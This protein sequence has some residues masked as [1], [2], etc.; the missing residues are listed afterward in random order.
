MMQTEISIIIPTLNEEKYLDTTLKALINQNTN[1]P[2]E[3]IVS[4]GGSDDG[5]IG[6]AKLYTDKVIHCKEVGIGYGR[7]F[8]A[9]KA[10]DSSKYFVFV[11]SDT[12]LPSYF[13][14]WMYDRFMNNPGVVAFST[15]FD[16][17]EQSQQLKLA[18]QV[19]NHYFE[20]R[21]KL[22]TTTLPGFITCVRKDSYF[23]CGGYRNV[24]LED[25]DFSRR[26]CKEGELRYYKDITVINSSRRLENMGLIGTI[27]Y[28][29]Q[30]D[31]GRK[32][33]STIVDKIKNKLGIADLRE[34]IGIRE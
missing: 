34:Y 1:V 18:Q 12:I 25:V 3:I 15:H 9:L 32:I 28:Y 26:I 19:S 22:F 33:D 24:L 29:A 31:I 10:S 16:F 2:Y 20:M 6:I 23:K 7:H 5:T 14:A 21:D 11:D 30:L 4:D 17:S 13:L 27:Y 8:G